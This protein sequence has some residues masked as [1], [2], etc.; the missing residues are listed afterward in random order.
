MSTLLVDELYDGV[1]FDQVIYIER[2]TNLIH[3]RPWIYKHGTL[4]DG[5]FQLEVIHA[6]GTVATVSLNYADINAAFTEN[7]AHGYIRFDFDSLALGISQGNIKEQFTLRFTMQNHTTD[8]D[9]FIGMVRNWE[10]QIYDLSEPAPNDSVK[11]VGIELY[12]LR[13]R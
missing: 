9:N 10:N 5:D 4:V 13:S 3:I 7:Y 6:N 12:E 2:P 11:P 1:T 8:T